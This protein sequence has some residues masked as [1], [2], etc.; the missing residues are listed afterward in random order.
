M[1]RWRLGDEKPRPGA[2]LESRSTCK[3]ISD[4]LEFDDILKNARSKWETTSESAVPCAAVPVK[5][6]FERRD[7]RSR[8]HRDTYCER[9]EKVFERTSSKCCVLANDHRGGAVETQTIGTE[10]SRGRKH[11]NH[12]SERGRVTKAKPIPIPESNANL[13]SKRCS[14]QKNGDKWQKP[15]TWEEAES[16]QVNLM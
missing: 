8:E 2:A 9:V 14:D 7:T 15:L 4:Y 13:W 16:E 11:Q 5:K 10:A 12:I 1:K 6:I 3:N